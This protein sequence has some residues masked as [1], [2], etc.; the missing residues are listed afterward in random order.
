MVENLTNIPMTTM[1]TIII[2]NLKKKPREVDLLLI[3]RHVYI[4]YFKYHYY[5]INIAKHIYPLT[6][7]DINI[8]QFQCAYKY[9]PKLWR[10][11]LFGIIII[12]LVI[13]YVHGI[14]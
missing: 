1:T 10:N 9:Y 11:K 12:I 6:S 8:A 14:Y 2:M 13:T 5:V 3:S 7:G 4:H